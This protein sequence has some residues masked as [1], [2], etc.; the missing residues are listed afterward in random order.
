MKNGMMLKQRTFTA[1]V[2]LAL[3]LPAVW[4]DSEP[5]H[6]FTIIVAIFG[7]GALIEFY[8]LAA[9]TE[10]KPLTFFGVVWALLFIISPHFNHAT[11][12]LTLITTATVLSLV[13]LLFRKPKET[14]FASWAWTMGGLFYV[15]WLLS[16]LVALR[17]VEHGRD[18]VLFALFCTF[19]SDTTSFFIGRA[20]GKRHM[21]PFISPNK[22]WEGAVSGAL[23]AIIVSLA[24]STAMSSFSDL[25][26][27]TG[28]LV[29]LGLTVSVFGQLGDLSKSL[30]KRN[31]GVKDSGK[32]LPGHGG[33]LDR[34]DSLIFAGMVVYYF[35]LAFNA[36][37]LNWLS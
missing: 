23:G 17:N 29:L 36:G 32:L 3:A 22:T 31:A 33:F 13:L 26:L 16:Y 25:S 18:W 4:F 35:A 6:W 19:A 1:L 12:P 2:A 7:T 27:S 9:R 15:G 28:Q 21:A 11:I 14:A 30:L 20:F 10:V 24:F 8:A 5:F 34:I 37:W